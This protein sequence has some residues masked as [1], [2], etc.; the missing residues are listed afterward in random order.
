[1]QK[2][3]IRP[4]QGLLPLRH[5]EGKNAGQA[6]LFTR[7]NARR[8]AANFC[9]VCFEKLNG[10]PLKNQINRKPRCGD[11]ERLHRRTKFG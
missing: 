10:I 3:T 11:L 5:S 8:I 2:S 1:M 6:K 7:D 9:V 4:A